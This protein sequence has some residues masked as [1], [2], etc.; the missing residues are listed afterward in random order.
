VATPGRPEHSASEPAAAPVARPAV[1]RPIG[2]RPAAPATRPAATAAAGPQT[3]LIIHG[4]IVGAIA[5]VLGIIWVSTSRGTFWPFWPVWPLAISVAIHAWVVVLAVQPTVWRRRGMTRGLAIQL[6]VSAALTAFFVGI[7]AMAGGGYFWPV[8]PFLGLAIP[9]AIH[10]VIVVVRRIEHLDA[11]RSDAVAVADTDLRRIERDLHDG[12]QARLVA[13]G[14]N[15]GLAEQRF[16]TDPEGARALVSEARQGVG[17][18]LAELRDLVRGIR[19]P[20]LADRGLE[21]AITALADRS[22][23]PVGV[24]ADIDRRPTDPVETAAY[25]VVAEALTNAAKHAD[26][27]R[28][29]VRLERRGNLLRVEVVDDGSGSA[30]ASGS[31]LVG[32]R[33]RV[34]ALQGN[35]VVTSPPGGPTI[36]RAELPCSS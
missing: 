25:F 26:A 6:G 20:V 17:D 15:L 5:V 3:A 24:T 33:R 28:V 34:E 9:A 13:L 32:L 35:L 19:P 12:A 14:M 29:D 2:P 21:A 11:A 31:G 1:N 7:W 16:E 4:G 18:A 23:L 22:P 27:T 8:W 30:D 10:W 36:V